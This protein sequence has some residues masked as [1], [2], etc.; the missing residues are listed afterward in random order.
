MIVYGDITVYLSD[1]E[2][3]NCLW[4]IDDYSEISDE[5]MIKSAITFPWLV[6]G[7]RGNLKYTASKSYSL[8]D[9]KDCGEESV[10]TYHDVILAKITPVYEGREYAVSWDY[11]F[12][13][14]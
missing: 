14:P 3:D 12:I 9:G 13:K 6:R 1:S 4:Y 5:I 7:W 10:Y 2:N 11:T 8:K